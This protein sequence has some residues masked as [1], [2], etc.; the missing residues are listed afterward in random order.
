MSPAYG[1]TMQEVIDDALLPAER[2]IRADFN[3]GELSDIPLS[4]NIANGLVSV[5]NILKSE[6][7]DAIVIMGDRS[8]LFA[9]SIASM[10]HKV[11][12]VHISGG[13]ISE[14]AIDENIRHATT[15]LSH[16]HL[17]ANEVCAMN[18]SR[19]GEE[20]WRIVVTGEPGIDNIYHQDQASPSDIKFR[21]GI[22]LSRPLLLV[23]LHPSTLEPGVPLR[24]Q[25][26]SLLKVLESLTKYQIII[27]APCADEGSTEMIN[28]YKNAAASNP[29]I[30]YI[31][32]LGSRYYLT[33]MRYAAALAGNSSSGFTEAP[34][35]SVPVVNIGN[36]Q[37][38]RMS[39]ENIIH[40]GYGYDEIKEALKK[41]TDRTHKKLCAEAFNPFD[42][43]KDGN[44]SL[45]AVSSIANFLEYMPP[46]KL[47]VKKFDTNTNSDLWNTLLKK[48]AGNPPS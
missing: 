4:Q 21:F 47:L 30:S 24:E 43:Y 11:P 12:L 19:M 44:N 16:L 36:R 33:L 25:Y 15:K 34:S 28:A 7:F 23:T 22:D 45:R 32:H 29:H 42:P 39:S 26:S 17:V 41:A 31:P 9:L 3:F 46:E 37:K 40:C 14:G 1:Y 27:T 13:E 6:N 35:L 48:P 10:L 8:E 18:V 2:I 38:N 20:D 5:D